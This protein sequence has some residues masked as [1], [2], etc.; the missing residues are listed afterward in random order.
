MENESKWRERAVQQLMRY[1]SLFKLLEDIQGTD[2]IA[3]ISNRIATQWKY[4]AS[5]NSWRMV[6]FQEPKVLIIDGFRGEAHIREAVELPVWDAYHKDLDRP[7]GSHTQLPPGHPSP[8]DHLAGSR[9]SEVR[10]IPFVRSGR[11]IALLSVAARHEP[12]SELDSKFNRI[13]GTYFADRISDILLR[14]QATLA[15]IKKATH[16]ALTGLCNRGEIIERF[17][18]TLALSRRTLQPASIIL[19][20]IDFFKII[21]DRYGHLVGDAVLREISRRMSGVLRESDSLGRYGGEEFLF[22]LYPCGMKE[23]SQMA[24]RFR[25]IVAASPV[26][27]S[28]TGDVGIN[29]SISLGTASTFGQENM[30]IDALLKQADDA[31]YRSKANGRNRV[32]AFT[33]DGSFAKTSP[34]H[35]PPG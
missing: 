29:V 12:F 17:R 5:V 2:D 14:R 31:L 9:I 22:V 23:V 25:N 34:N 21:N 10:V 16:D 24:E 35:L 27:G 1:E 30:G 19:A 28:D 8:P 15:L 13:F 4:F 7:C 20:D 6:V 26:I 3:T 11:W 18:K 33:L 32:T